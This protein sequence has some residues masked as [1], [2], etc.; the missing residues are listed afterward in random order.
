MPELPEVETVKRG[1]EDILVGSQIIKVDVHQPKL[2]YPIPNNLQ[3]K[4]Q[5]KHIKK[6]ERKAKYL[7]IHTQEDLAIVCHLGMSGSLTYKN[8][9]ELLNKHDHLV[10]KIKSPHKKGEVFNIVY[11]D[12]RRFG[13][14]DLVDIDKL[15]EW[16]A[17]RDTGVEPLSKGFTGIHLHNLLKNKSISIKQAIMNTKNVVGIGNI[18][19]CESLFKSGIHPLRHSNSLSKQ[20]CV[21]LVAQIKQVLK[22]AIAVGGSSLKDHKQADGTLGYFQHNFCVYQKGGEN[23]PICNHKISKIKQSG[24][25]TFFCENCQK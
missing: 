23:C 19:A 16:P 13:L 3:K 12:P 22:E 5:N 14:I 9:T 11:N 17:F 4:L 25:G 18:Y 6:L 24:R 7:V 8:K 1:L 20:E 10:F 2:R 21:K 15:N